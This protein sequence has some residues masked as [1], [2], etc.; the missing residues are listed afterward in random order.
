MNTAWIVLGLVFILVVIDWMIGR[1]T[2]KRCERIKD[3]SIQ[4]IGE[5]WPEKMAEVDDLLNNS[6]RIRCKNCEKRFEKYSGV[7]PNNLYFY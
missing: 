4:S 7:E 1:H 2:I 5:L 3:I 6:L